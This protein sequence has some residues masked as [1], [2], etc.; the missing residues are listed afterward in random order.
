[1]GLRRRR[2]E[3][4]TADGSGFLEDVVLHNKMEIVK[5]KEKKKKTKQRIDTPREFDSE[6]SER[7]VTRSHR[8]RRLLYPSQA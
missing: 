6:K 8:K 7:E 2:Q 4:E 3:E 1:M 5:V